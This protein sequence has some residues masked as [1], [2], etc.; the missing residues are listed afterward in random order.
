MGSSVSYKIVKSAYK[1]KF[2][3][4]A[5]CYGN[6]S[7][8]RFTSINGPSTRISAQI[9]KIKIGSFCSIAS[10]VIIQ[11][12][13]HK[14]NRLSS[15]YMNHYLFNKSFKNDIFS[16]GNIIIQDDVWIG[17]NSVILS[18]VTIGRGAIVGAG[19]VVTR[20]VP[21]YS[22][23]AGNPARVIKKRFSDEVISQVKK[24]EW[25]EWDEEKIKKNRHLFN[26]DLVDTTLHQ[27]DI[28]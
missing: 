25:W 6:V 21:E 3:N 23:V 4:G 18:G 24:L 12:Y 10:G 22:I 26:L 2:L 11:E 9:N 13:Y 8:G 17:S 1:C 15:Y 7:I 5:I 20:D 19:S 14:Y 27:K 28:Q 16:K